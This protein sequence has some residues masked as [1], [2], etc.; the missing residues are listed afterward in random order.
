MLIPGAGDEVP[1]VALEASV[2]GVLEPPLGGVHGSK[3]ANRPVCGYGERPKP[4]APRYIH[5]CHAEKWS[6]ELW[7]KDRPDQIRRL[8]AR[9]MSWRHDGPCAEAK[10]KQDYARIAEALDGED[11]ATVV[12]AVFTLDPSAWSAAGW[13]GPATERIAGALEN[14]RA[15]D[16]AYKELVVRWRELIRRIRQEYG[17]VEYV[18]TVEAHRSG[19]P[20]LNVILVSDILARAVRMEDS[21]L[22]GWARKAR[23]REVARNV[24]WGMLEQSG[25]GPM[26]FAEVASPLT[27]DG[28]DRLAAYISKLSN[29][30][31]KPFE[32]DCGGGLIDSIEGRLVSELVKLSQTPHDAPPNFRRLRCSKGFLPPVRRNPDITGQMLDEWGRRVGK[33]QI[34][35]IIGA[36][37]RVGTLASIETKKA[38][39]ARAMAFLADLPHPPADRDA[40]ALHHVLCVMWAHAPSVPGA[41]RR[42]VLAP[43]WYRPP[44]QAEEPPD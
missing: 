31:G 28:K 19:W 44:D 2:S 20:H 33:R 13:T 17:A 4:N 41:L 25:F 10:A 26:A 16:A 42:R 23:G 6:L 3:A 32:G 12:Y 5:A 8:P 22:D 15:M 14:Q 40:V 30:V 38:L 24:F 36:I 29:S 37:D 1:S 39:H 35:A 11:R 18:A 43:L 27:G 34:D 9:C 21:C 7:P